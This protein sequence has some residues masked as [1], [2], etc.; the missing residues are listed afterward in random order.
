MQKKLLLIIFFLLIVS[1]FLR[2]QNFTDLQNGF[3][4]LTGASSAWADYDG[5]EDLD[6]ALSGFSSIQAELGRIYRNDGNGVFTVIKNLDFPV[7]DGA[8]SWGDFDHDGDPDLLVNG[9]GGLFSPPAVTTLYRN[10]GND[11]FT[12]ISSGLP[13]VIGISRWIDYDGDGWQDV[14]MAGIGNSFKADSIRLFHND[15]TGEFTEVQINLPGCHA[16]DIS[17]VDFDMD[18][19]L[20]FFLTGGTLSASTD[21]VTRLYKNE[22]NEIFN[23]VQFPFINLSTGTTKWADYDHD[24]DPDVL[25]DGIDSTLVFPMTLIYRNNGLDQ[26]TLIDANLPGSGEPGS[27]DWA[28]IDGDGDLDILLGGPTTLLRNDGNNVYTD[29]TPVDFQQ[30]IPCSFADMDNDGDQD[31]LIVSASGG[32]TG[33]S[34]HRNENI[35]AIHNAY[36]QSSSFVFPNPVDDVL[37][38]HPGEKIIGNFNFRLMNS[39]G[40][41]V[42]YQVIQHHDESTEEQI[43]LSFLSPGLY[44]YTI[45]QQG[46]SIHVG[47]VIV[48]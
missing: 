6:F 45:I 41:E 20:D 29:I 32:D 15:T 13:G 47:K 19:D 38:I 3:P 4:S 9:Q 25:Y 26:F 35:T 46:L 34:I 11:D 39:I 24:G 27:V 28:D 14:I 8:V 43:N 17:I 16:T 33:S 23:Q 44:P 10:N 30:G 18:G 1:P 21:P 22:G 42:M 40:Q 7:S 2:A 31:I 48:N 36:N 12:P 5:D 37:T